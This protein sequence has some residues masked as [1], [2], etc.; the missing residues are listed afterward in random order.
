MKFICENCHTKYSIADDRVHGRVLKIRCKTCDHVITVREERIFELEPDPEPEPQDRTVISSEPRPSEDEWF[1]SFDG[2]QEGP[3]TLAAALERVR[4]EV[5]RGKDAHAWRPGFF[6]WLPVEEVSEFAPAL[7]ARP[8][9]SARSV[10]APAKKASLAAVEAPREDTDQTQAPPV[11]EPEPAGAGDKIDSK[12]TPLPPLPGQPMTPIALSLLGSKPGPAEGRAGERDSGE[13]RLP[14]ASPAP[15]SAAARP[16]AAAGAA[17]QPA[18]KI[19]LHDSGPVPLPPPPGGEDLVFGEPSATINLAHLMGSVAPR[20]SV[21]AAEPLRA[22]PA[23]PADAAL[24]PVE[25]TAPPP[26]HGAASWV[27]WSVV[28]LLL[29]TLS[30]GGAVVYLMAR[31]APLAPGQALVVRRVDDSPIGVI[32]PGTPTSIG[33][34]SAPS[35]PKRPAPRRARPKEAPG[36]S[37]EQKSLAALYSDEGDKS[38]PREAPLAPTARAQGQVSQTAILAVVTQNRRSLNLCYDRVLKHDSSLKRARL[39]THVKVG[40][41]GTVTSVSIP[42]SEYSNAE[43]GTCIT[44]TIKHW[45]FPSSD[46]EYETEFPILLQAD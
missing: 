38:Q 19:D 41:S 10:T 15:S 22:P 31:P 32:D 14:A 29:A 44:Q 30:L 42:D 37:S 17:A 20:P 46:A 13:L 27:K 23:A 18:T 7:K 24:A 2:E 35:D 40:L 33:M 8:A 39:V 6:V 12:P 16:V 25:P 21:P 4:A 1:V 36:L 9:K 26:R 5:P 28:V 11:P 43:I 3:M 45:H 34:P